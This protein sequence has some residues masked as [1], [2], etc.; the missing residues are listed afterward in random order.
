MKIKLSILILFIV[1][2]SYSQSQIERRD[3][4]NQ[5][6]Y[7]F[8][9]MHDNSSITISK[10]KSS[11]ISEISL[12]LQTD[13]EICR[14]Y[15]QITLTLSSGEK[16]NF[17]NAKIYCSTSETNKHK[18]IGTIILNKNL[19]NKLSQTEIKSFELGDVKIPVE[20]KETG[21]NLRGL[22]KFSEEY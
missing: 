22:F 1:S 20:F 18:L 8:L 2:I 21:E 11:T 15:N 9:L 17:E 13:T 10:Y 7:T 19:Y 12:L 5:N 16:I 4:V 6:D 3:P 14:D